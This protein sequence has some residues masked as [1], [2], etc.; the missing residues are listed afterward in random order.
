MIPIFLPLFP[1]LRPPRIHWKPRPSPQR[2]RY[3]QAAPR[4]HPRRSQQIRTQRHHELQTRG[5]SHATLKEQTRRLEEEPRSRR[6]VISIHDDQVFIP[7]ISF[8]QHFRMTFV[9]E[10]IMLPGHEHGGDETLLDVAD[11]RNMLDIESRL[12]FHR[13]LDHAH[14]HRQDKVGYRD[15]LLPSLLHHFLRE[16]R[17]V[18]EG[19]IQ[20]H[21]RD[22]GIATAVHEGGGG[23]HGSS[24]EG[25]VG[26][27]S[28]G[29]E[30]G[31]DGLEVFSFVV[32]EGNVVSFGVAGAGEVEGEDGDA[33]AEEVA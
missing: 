4:Q 29:A 6:I 12:M 23:S 31:G 8:V 14:D 15:P 9:Y 2:R 25:D 32:S 26:E 3:A 20:D 10:I 16:S 24:P 27:V 7:R 11:G 1:I 17:E 21:A 5:Q 33:E 19:R 30:V 28:R 18:R 22:G 13:T